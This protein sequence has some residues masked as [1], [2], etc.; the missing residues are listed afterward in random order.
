MCLGVR[1]G[2]AFFE[3]S[4]SMHF[5]MWWGSDQTGNLKNFC[6]DVYPH[7]SVRAL[8]TKRYINNRKLFHAKQVFSWITFNSTLRSRLTLKSK[9]AFTRMWKDILTVNHESQI[10]KSLNHVSQGKNSPNHA[11][12]KKYRGPSSLRA[13]HMLGLTLMQSTILSKLVLSTGLIMWIGHHKETRELTFQ[14][15]AHSSERIRRANTRNVSL[16]HQLLQSPTDTA[17]QF[18]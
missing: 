6:A 1:K 17:P 5:K 13:I 15:L 11:S 10:N 7:L 12:R 3:W 8:K 16:K 14:A 4:N 2:Y 18:F 9:I